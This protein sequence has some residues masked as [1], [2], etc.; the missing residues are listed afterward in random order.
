MSNPIN[1]SASTCAYNNGGG[2]YASSI[3]VN[4]ANANTTSQTN[5]ATYQD[6]TSSSFT[7]CSGECNCAKTSSISCEA[8]Q[9][10]HNENGCC[11]A[12][13]VKINIQN[14]SCETFIGQ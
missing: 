5:C 6:K 3:K 1:C 11:K 4:G 13:S 7:N 8:N 2:C 12:E 9:C 14:A 10:K